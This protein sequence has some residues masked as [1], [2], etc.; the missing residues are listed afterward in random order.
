MSGSKH[1]SPTVS[2]RRHER[3]A[4][5]LAA[6]GDG[7]AEHEVLSVQ[8]RHSHHVGAVY[9]TAA[10]LVYRSLTGPHAHGR[11]DLPDV[12]HHGAHHGEVYVELLA[13]AQEDDPLPGWCD[14]GSWSLARRDL[15]SD[16]RA[17]V[18]TTHVS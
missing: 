2:S 14:C 4:E 17:R 10:G 9:D 15:L 7:L 3:A 18:R 8:C 13:E 16:V 11:K 6:L 1:G 12:A 5:A